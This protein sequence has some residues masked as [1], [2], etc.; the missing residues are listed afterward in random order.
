MDIANIGGSIGNDDN[1]D[2]N[3]RNDRI[4]LW[5]KPIPALLQE[6]QY[7]NGTVDYNNNSDYNNTVNYIEGTLRVLAENNTHRS[8]DAGILWKYGNDR[9]YYLSLKGSG[10]ELSQRE[11]QVTNPLSSH[12]NNQA[13]DIDEES[14]KTK[15]SLLVQNQEIRRERGIWY[16]IKILMVDDSFINIYV[17]DMLRMQ[18]PI[19]NS[20]FNFNIQL[21]LQHPSHPPHPPHP[22]Y[23][24]HRC[25]PLYPEWE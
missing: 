12:S 10:L 7:N 25:L 2:G 13:E 11:K 4:V 17:D 16:N 22:P 14:E 5:S 23:H 1:N 20:Y 9:E 6:Q 18:V 24:L 8:N 21:Q 3:N 15:T 19:R